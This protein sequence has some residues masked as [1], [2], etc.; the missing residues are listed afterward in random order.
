MAMRRPTSGASP[1]PAKDAGAWLRPGPQG[2]DLGLLSCTGETATR[3]PP[4][5]PVGF[6]H[7]GKE[8]E[9]R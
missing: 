1:W 6:F 4:H 7:G 9:G 2:K 3:I 5:L 8:D